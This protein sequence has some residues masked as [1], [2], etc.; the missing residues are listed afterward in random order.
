M[1]ELPEVESIKKQLST[2]ITGRKIVK[3][4]ILEEKQFRGDKKKIIGAV[5]EK[6][7]RRAKLLG[8]NLN[9]GLI[10][11]THL[12]LTGEF[13]FTEKK[14]KTVSFD[15]DLPFGDNKL[16]SK[17]TRIII[18]FDDGAR[19]FFNDL[20]KFGWMRIIKNSK[21]KIQNSKFGP[22]P[23]EKEFTVEY[24]KKAFAK[25][26]RAIKEVLLDQKIMAGIGNIYACEILFRA[27]VDPGRPANSLE[28]EEIEN[29]HRAIIFILKEAIKYHG[30][31]AADEAYIQPDTEPG[32]YKN[33]LRVY[34]RAGKKCFRCS[35]VV[36][37]IKQGGRSTYFCSK[38]QK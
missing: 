18:S 3:V 11:L 16:P 5:V 33:K 4:V 24:L 6:V 15:H 26:R 19:L 38:C 23:L 14:G 20:R 34:N 28:A 30:T 9:N 35:G 13:I 10:L 2:K 37:R 29:I 25:T 1:P 36:K 27:K 22:E 31:S 21:L 8:I 17:H 32:L 7:W 12:K